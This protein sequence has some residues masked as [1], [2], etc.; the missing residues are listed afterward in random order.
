MYF[1]IITSKYKTQ[2]PT[3]ILITNFRFQALSIPQYQHFKIPALSIHPEPNLLLFSTVLIL[4]IYFQ[5]IP[6]YINSSTIPNQAKFH[7]SS[8]HIIPNSTLFTKFFV[9]LVHL[10]FEFPKTFRFLYPIQHQRPLYQIS[11]F[12]LCCFSKHLV[13]YHLVLFG[14]NFQSQHHIS[15]LLT[16]LTKISRLYRYPF[17]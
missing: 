14:A 16:N 5:K 15:T 13:Q 10:L 11:D 2:T 12:L 4:R 17:T 8:I 3:G 1:S 9:L 6:P 7:D